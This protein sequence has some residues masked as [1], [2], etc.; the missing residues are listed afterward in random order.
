MRSP[1]L[2]GLLAVAAFYGLIHGGPLDLPV[3]HRYFTHHPVEYGET[4]LFSIGMAALLLRLVDVVLQR[5]NLLRSPWK[6]IASENLPADASYETLQA[7][8]D[9]SRRFVKTNITWADS[10]RRCSS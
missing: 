6:N 10:A 4:I 7:E 9:A 1:I 8:L 2:W 5:A 3:M